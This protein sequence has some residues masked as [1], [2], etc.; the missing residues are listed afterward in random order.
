M[1]EFILFV[2][3]I[4]LFF[5]AASINNRLHEAERKLL[6]GLP[7]GKPAPVMPAHT[8]ASVH[9]FWTQAPSQIPSPEPL[10]TLKPQ[11]S[12]E[13]VAANW[14]TRIGVL[15][16]IFGLAFF[17][18]YAIDQGWISQWT[19]VILGIVTGSLLV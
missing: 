10:P 2:S 1:L 12:E 16:L 3:V 15:A 4:V 18:K 7:S 9:Q 11:E 17:L 5:W 13:Q 6:Q 8:D 19:R 14:L